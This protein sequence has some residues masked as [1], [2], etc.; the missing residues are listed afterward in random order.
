ML[1]TTYYDFVI[2]CDER[3]EQRVPGIGL[4]GL[5]VKRRKHAAEMGKAPQMP[6]EADGGSGEMDPSEIEICKTA[7]G[8]D[9][10]LGAGAFGQVRNGHA[11]D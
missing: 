11:A 8:S 5:L 2:T 6:A 4:L 1:S 10:F 3:G 9:W 7:D